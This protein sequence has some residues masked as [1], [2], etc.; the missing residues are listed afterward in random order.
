MLRVRIL[1][2]MRVELDGRAIEPP[3][4]RGAWSLLAYL[5]IHPGPHR[6]G[7]V[8]ARFWPDV[9]DSSARQ[10]LRSAVWALRRAL[11]PGGRLVVTTR[12][13]IS[14][15]PADGLWVDVLELE[16]R[17]A[18]GQLRDALA[19][20]EGE[21]LAG[22]DE[23]WALQARAAHR[24][25]ISEAFEALAVKADSDGHHELAVRLTRREVALDRLDEAAHRRLMTRLAAAGD[26]SGALSEYELLRERLRREL[27]IV[28]SA[29]TRA[30]ADE[31]RHGDLETSGAREVPALFRPFA[32]VGRDRELRA[33]E[34]TWNLASSGNGGV[35]V[36]TGEPGIGK[37]RLAVELLARV[38][39]RGARTA[40]CAALDLAG[41]APLGLWAELIRDLVEQLEPPP[42][43][44][45]WPSDLA[46]LSPDIEQRFGRERT[47]RPAIAPDLERARLYQ[48]AIELLSWAA[49]RR[50][51]VVLIEDIHIADPPSLELGAFIGRQATRL[52]LLI[53]MTRRPLPASVPADALEQAL[54]GRSALR[55]ELELGP[56]DDSALATLVRE[57]GSL[58]DVHVAQTVA[59]AEGNALLAIEHARA[60]ARGRSEPPATL[61]AAVRTA[62]A[63]LSPEP[64]LVAEFAAAARREL[65]REELEA[66]PVAAPIDAATAS[67]ETGLLV[68]SSGKLGYRHAL[69]REAVYA[70]LPDPRR[71]WLHQHLAEVLARHEDLPGRA[72][73]VA[74]HLK[75]AGRSSEAAQHLARAAKDARSVA[76][77]EQAAGFLQ[78]AIDLTGEDTQLLL[79]LAEVEAWRQRAET[80]DQIFT[81]AVATLPQ[82]GQQ[83]ADAWLRRAYWNRGTLC[84]PHEVLDSARRALAALDIHSPQDTVIRSR[85]LAMAAWAEAI[86]GDPDEAERLLA[87]VQHVAGRSAGDSDLAHY[88]GHARALALVRRGLFRE[89]YAPQTAAGDAAERIGRPDL[90]GGCWLN[91]ACV[92]ACAGEFER[93]LGF[94]ERGERTIAGQRLIWYEVHFLA[95]RAYV[96][97]RL[98]RLQE[99]WAAAEQEAAAAERADTP[100][101][102]A[103]AEHDQGMIALALAD[104]ARA[105]ELLREALNHGARVSRPLARLARAEALAKLGHCDEAD[106][107]LTAMALEPVS[108]G[109]FPETLVPRMS[110]IQGLIAAAHGDTA[111]AARRLEEAAAGWRRVH[112]PSS[113]GERYT[114]SFAD[115]A[116]PPVLGLVEPEHE[117]DRVLGEL[118]TLDKAP[119]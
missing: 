85:A 14:L 48:A 77:L 8:A 30:L 118:A 44:A 18:E 65:A 95:A 72:A 101:L 17:L 70:D 22:F 57:V 68:A 40:S 31:L 112:D 83:L 105:A 16:Q 21:L 80:S 61:R 75:L 103:T 24:D 59:A 36:I 86:T 37:T 10:S 28:P 55:C 100:E 73:E 88:V 20:G 91:A 64:R 63:P 60:L 32:L 71:G 2:P 90:A 33:L 89:S 96:L 1:G 13:E 79:E 25:R 4:K 107:E 9:L 51:L 19:V 119:A 47:S 115:L 23:E 111:L 94:I 62:L 76:A 84:R 110:R 104:H 53:V 12:E 93:A 102:R 38:S 74:R 97:A 11:G 49:R 116:R 41:A 42:A 52:P 15:D 29:P 114:S 45:A 3:A 5:A 109:D 81:R 7:D 66:L 35:A 99:A 58:Q 56:L 82:S 98:G 6:R 34:Q 67:L 43:D 108:P 69:L 117:L 54:R 78:E 46:A 50:P 26:R 87:E 113:D 106:D 39:D 92:A 27:G